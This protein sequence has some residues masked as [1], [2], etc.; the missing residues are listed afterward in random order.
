[1]SKIDY[2]IKVG[3]TQL[4]AAKMVSLVGLIPDDELVFANIESQREMK[5][6]EG[7]PLPYTPL[8]KTL[9]WEQWRNL[10]GEINQKTGARFDKGEVGMIS[11]FKIGINAPLI[12]VRPPKE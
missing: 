12:A 9:T 4:N 7:K 6:E 5:D 8:P 10:V 11:L 2:Y 3:A 1:M